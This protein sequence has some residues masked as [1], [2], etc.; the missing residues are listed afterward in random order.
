MG[1]YKVPGGGVYVENCKKVM[2]GFFGNLEVVSHDAFDAFLFNLE[3]CKKTLDWKGQKPGW[4]YGPW[5]EDLFMQNCMDVHG[6]AKVSNFTL[7]NDGLCKADLPKAL[8]KVKGVK[9]HPDC[10]HSQ[11][12]SLHPFMKPQEY[13]ACLA[14]TQRTWEWTGITWRHLPLPQ[15]QPAASFQASPRTAPSAP[16][17]SEGGSVEPVNEDANPE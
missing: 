5:G 1:G 10:S 16:A 15:P 3:H 9:W 17:V 13:F 14:N 12:V 7:T 11:A 8:Q 2:Y 4:K 6:V